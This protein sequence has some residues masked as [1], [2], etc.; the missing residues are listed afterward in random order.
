MLGSS[1]RLPRSL[2]SRYR[3]PPPVLFSY[4][5]LSPGYLPVRCVRPCMFV[6]WRCLSPSMHS[7]V[8]SRLSPLY[9][10]V[11]CRCVSGSAL[12]YLP[13][14]GGGGQGPCHLVVMAYQAP[15]RPLH[16]QHLPTRYRWDVPCA[17]TRRHHVGSTFRCRCCRLGLLVLSRHSLSSLPLPPSH[18]LRSP[19][20]PLLSSRTM[21]LGRCQAACPSRHWPSAWVGPRCPPRSPTGTCAFLRGC[22][23]QDRMD[24][25]VL[26]HLRNDGGSVGTETRAPLLDDANQHLAVSLLHHEMCGVCCHRPC[27]RFCISAA[28][29]RQIPMV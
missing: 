7:P 12:W 15:H 19:H 23:G 1:S 13:V 28:P 5:T 16:R 18:P 8:R 27:S 3:T 25:D 4:V 17:T 6:I 29:T 22:L 21:W 20:L 26:P 9:A 10:R 2:R 11:C 14:S 24:G